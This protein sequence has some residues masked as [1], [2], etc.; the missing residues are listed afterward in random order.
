MNTD[1]QDTALTVQEFLK[2]IRNNLKFIL[3]IA[4]LG[5]TISAS[6]SLLVQEIYTATALMQTNNSK[7][8]GANTATNSL[9]GMAQMVGISA[10]GGGVSPEWLSYQMLLSREFFEV[11]YNDD[12]FMAKIFAHESYDKS[13]RAESYNSSV[14]DI[15]TSEWLVAK[16]S[17]AEAYQ[18]FHQNYFD[19]IHDIRKNTTELRFYHPSPVIATELLKQAIRDINK[20]ATLDDKIEAQKSLDYLKIQSANTA[21]LEVKTVIASLIQKQVQ[22]L[23]LAEV[24]DE[25]LFKVIDKPYEPFY[26]EYP[27]RT[28]MVTVATIS[29]SFIALLFAIFSFINRKTAYDLLKELISRD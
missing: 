23:M 18:H 4:I 12:T 6:Y 28:Q 29:A 21:L 16:P 20:F 17:M 8:D 25:Y 26:R 1:S 2:A 7:N 9:T 19:V 11:L 14:Y 13:T 10:S 22:T 5:F 3:V 15:E 24:S 27:K